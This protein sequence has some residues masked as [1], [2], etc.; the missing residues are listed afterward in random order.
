MPHIG[1]DSFPQPFSVPDVEAKTESF[2][3]NRLDPQCGQRVPLQSA[4][5]TRTSLSRSQPAQWNS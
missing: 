5:R 4:E 2:F 1:A 3:V